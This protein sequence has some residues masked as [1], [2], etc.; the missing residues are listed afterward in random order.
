MVELSRR[1]IL[2]RV[3]GRMNLKFPGL[4]ALFFGLMLAD[5]LIP[6]FIP[7]VD[8]IGFTLLAA[9][10]GLWKKRRSAETRPR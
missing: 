8:E 7:F 4:F 1:G 5:F 6:D 2:E 9:L 10:F 3:L